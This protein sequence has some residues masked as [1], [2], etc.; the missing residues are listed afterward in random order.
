[1]CLLPFSSAG[2]LSVLLVFLSLLRR[3]V[4]PEYFC[5]IYSSFSPMSCSLSSSLTSVRVSES[6][7]DLQQLVPSS[8]NSPTP[9]GDENDDGEVD[10]ESDSA[11][12]GSRK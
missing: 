2:L 6:I 9:G 4:Y 5:L 10:G 11:D 8:D 12:R 1:M 3:V 7:P